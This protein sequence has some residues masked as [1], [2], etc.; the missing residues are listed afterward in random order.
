MTPDRVSALIALAG[1]VRTPIDEART[2]ALLACRELVRGR[3]RV[4]EHDAVASTSTW[5]KYTRSLDGKAVCCRCHRPIRIGRYVVS[6]SNGDT[7]CR[8][9]SLEEPRW[10]G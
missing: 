2:A 6:Y 3:W 1:D 5:P 8:P 4:V 7:H 9:C 10:P